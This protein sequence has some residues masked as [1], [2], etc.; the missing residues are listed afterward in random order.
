MT[1]EKTKVEL[2]KIRK[3]AEIVSVIGLV[4]ILIGAAMALWG[5]MI[6]VGAMLPD[7]EHI[8]D[9]GMPVRDLENASYTWTA[10]EIEKTL[11]TQE[12]WFIAALVF[13]LPGLALFYGM[14]LIAPSKREIHLIG[15]RKPKDYQFCPECGAAN[16][17]CPECG[18]KLSELKEK[19]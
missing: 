1:E 4:L 12:D 15:C 14:V 10:D 11:D 9:Q 13:L 3:K 18:L 7:N 2:E 5:V 16:K 19:D 6:P 17:Y 8:T